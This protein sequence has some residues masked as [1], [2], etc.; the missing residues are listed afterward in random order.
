MNSTGSLILSRSP[1]HL[2]ASFLPLKTGTIKKRL[3]TFYLAGQALQLIETHFPE[4][5]LNDLASPPFDLVEI[6]LTLYKLVQ[7]KDWFEVDWETVLRFCHHY[8]ESGGNTDH[9][10]LLTT[11]IPLRVYGNWRTDIFFRVRPVLWGLLSDKSKRHPIWYHLLHI[12]KNP[13]RYPPHLA[14]LPLMA[15]WSIC[16]GTGNAI[17]DTCTSLADS[18]MLMRSINRLGQCWFVFT[19]PNDI[20]QVRS[21]WQQAKPIIGMFRRIEEWGQSQRN[22]DRLVDFIENGEGVNGLNW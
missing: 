7:E 20:D 11:F 6:I 15:R 14:Y 1:H 18:M 19:W 2:L 17:L 4:M 13:E 16:D 8:Q 3:N 9:L 5:P 10:G 22:I 12:E 21:E